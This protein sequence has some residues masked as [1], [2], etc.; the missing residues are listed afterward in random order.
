MSVLNLT[1]HTHFSDFHA[2]PHQGNILIRPKALT[3]SSPFNFD[4]VLLD[5]GQYFDVPEDLRVNYA[6]LWLALIARSSPK[7]N[8]ERRKYAKLVGNIDDDLVSVIWSN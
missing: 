2:D 7:I 1:S 5:H 4:C 6:R 3:S 8:L